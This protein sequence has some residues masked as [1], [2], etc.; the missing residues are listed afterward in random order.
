MVDVN[1][2]KGVFDFWRNIQEKANNFSNE[3]TIEREKLLKINKN[4]IEMTFSP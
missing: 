1:P 4:K 2:S 3:I